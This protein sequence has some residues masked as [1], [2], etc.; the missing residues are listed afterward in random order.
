M[1]KHV[2]TADDVR[3][4]AESGERELMLREHTVLTDA[5]VDAADQ[6]GIRL[7]EGST[8][9]PSAPSPTVPA[10]PGAGGLPSPALG[11]LTRETHSRVAVDAPG[12][13]HPLPREERAAFLRRPSRAVPRR[14]RATSSRDRRRRR[15]RGSRACPTGQR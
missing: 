9:S 2:V 5:A 10:R 3:R 14:R 4:L 15:S 11:G 1:S 7:V 13:H 6:L 8:F 12:L